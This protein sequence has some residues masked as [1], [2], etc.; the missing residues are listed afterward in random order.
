MYFI[1]FYIRRSQEPA[2]EKGRC[3]WRQGVWGNVGRERETPQ[4]A[5]PPLGG[6]KRDSG[7]H[8]PI[9]WCKNLVL[10]K[11]WAN[12]RK[13]ESEMQEYSKQAWALGHL[14]QDPDPDWSQL[15]QGGAAHLLAPPF[16]HVV[17]T[18]LGSTLFQ[19]HFSSLMKAVTLGTLPTLQAPQDVT[20]NIRNR[21]EG[22]KE[23]GKRSSAGVPA[24][25]PRDV[26]CFP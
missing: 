15:P 5:G 20:L 4:K 9:K 8:A 3:C 25:I 10:S 21:R 23:M 17:G 1:Y 22:I 6:G 7:I 16:L 12:I 19:W 2:E 18:W 26:L 24:I 13:A 11:V 14:W